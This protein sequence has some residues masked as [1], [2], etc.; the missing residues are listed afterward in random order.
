MPENRLIGIRRLIALI[1][2]AQTKSIALLCYERCHEECHRSI[3]TDL[4][5]DQIDATIIAIA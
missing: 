5:S 1:A 4:L 3:I 2:L